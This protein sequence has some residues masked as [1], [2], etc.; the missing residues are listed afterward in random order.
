MAVPRAYPALVLAAGY[1]TRCRP[2]S[3]IRAKPAL[4][5]AGTPVVSRLLGHLRATGVR[6]AVINLHHKP[7]TITSLVGDGS[8]FGVRVQYSR[9]PVLLG[10]AGGPRRALPLLDAPRFLVINGDTLSAVDVGALVAAHESSGAA[11]TMALGPNPD[12]QRYGGVFVDDEGRVR[13]FGR[14]GALSPEP[15]WRSLHFVGVQAA[16]AAVFAPL[17]DGGPAESVGGLYP[18]LLADRP[19]AIR[20]FE[21][22]AA[23]HDIGTPADYL[24]TSL[25][26]AAAEDAP[27]IPPGRGTAI[28]PGA[29]LVRTA[30]WDE[31]TIE[32]SCHLSECVI[33]DRVKLP[34][35][36]RLTG[37]A[38]VRRSDLPPGIAGDDRTG[39]YVVDLQL[40]DSRE[41]NEP[42]DRDASSPR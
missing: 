2:L 32:A 22:R 1:G 12:P 24:V 4:P 30:V 34:A 15:S 19:G 9:E 31:V 36:T 18:A 40:R 28:D 26:V 25:A 10:S 27:G 35:D 39:L 37:C 23:F 8:A 14:A 33:A 11:V 17:P 6:D 38:V 21:S 3:W 41:E 29:V 16:D 13:G 20:A 5:V 42:D 7:E